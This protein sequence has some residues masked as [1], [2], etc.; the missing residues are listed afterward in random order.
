MALFTNDIYQIICEYSYHLDGYV[1]NARA[2]ILIKKNGINIYSR[3]LDESLNDEDRLDYI[4]DVLR[5]KM[6]G[7]PTKEYAEYGRK[8]TGRKMNS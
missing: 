7:S 8:K 6:T 3:C 1:K 4:L 5:C 2:D